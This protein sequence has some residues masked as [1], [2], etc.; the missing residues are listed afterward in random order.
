[1]MKCSGYDDDENSWEY[2]HEKRVEIPE[3]VALYFQINGIADDGIMLL[4]SREEFVEE[5]Q[6][7]ERTFLARAAKKPR[8]R[9]CKFL[10]LSIFDKL[11]DNCKYLKYF[12][13]N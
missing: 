6:P 1:L 8:F 5:R 13:N 12:Y 10:K 4:R 2:G 7:R 9:T 11:F 3:A